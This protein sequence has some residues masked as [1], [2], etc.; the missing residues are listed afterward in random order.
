MD[1]EGDDADGGWQVLIM[2][3]MTAMVVVAC[4][5][6]DSDGLLIWIRTVMIMVVGDL[7]GLSQ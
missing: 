6:Y 7:Y 3:V 5:D 2:T 1:Y 4:M